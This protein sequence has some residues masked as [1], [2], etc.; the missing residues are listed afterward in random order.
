MPANGLYIKY[1]I[2]KFDF[3]RWEELVPQTSQEELDKLAQKIVSVIWASFKPTNEDL[4][5]FKM[6]GLKSLYNS[7]IIVLIVKNKKNE[8]MRE[9]ENVIIDLMDVEEPESFGGDDMEKIEEKE[10]EKERVI[11]LFNL[12]SSTVTYQDM[13]GDLSFDLKDFVNYYQIQLGQI[14]QFNICPTQENFLINFL[15]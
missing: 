10:E 8:S 12:Q 1:N 5:R 3:T 9:R 15:S 14:I 13:Y 11:M 2:N 4:S 7:D 6:K